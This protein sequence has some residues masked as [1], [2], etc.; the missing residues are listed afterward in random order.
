MIAIDGT[1]GRS[2]LSALVA[3]FRV[4]LRSSCLEG[5]SVSQTEC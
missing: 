2:K 5:F 4:I 1:L 3:R